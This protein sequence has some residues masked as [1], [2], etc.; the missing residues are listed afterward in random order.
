MMTLYRFFNLSLEEIENLAKRVGPEKLRGEISIP[1]HTYCCYVV[2]K[3]SVFNI[4]AAFINPVMSRPEDTDKSFGYVL[5]FTNRARKTIV[6]IYFK[7]KGDLTH[8]HVSPTSTQEIEDKTVTLM[9][10]VKS[11]YK[12]NES[13]R[14]TES[15]I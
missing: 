8:I 11:E 15:V 6:S 13:R 4:S 12:K 9:E 1:R 7:F 5:S 10:Y 2:K 3:S 14:D